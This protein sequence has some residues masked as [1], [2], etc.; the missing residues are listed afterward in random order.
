MAEEIVLSGLQW[1]IREMNSG[2]QQ[3]RIKVASGLETPYKA[4]RNAADQ[5][6]RTIWYCLGINEGLCYSEMTQDAKNLYWRI[7]QLVEALHKL[8]KTLSKGL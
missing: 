1:K 6:M 5:V 4:G 7:S 2:I 8:E 3:M